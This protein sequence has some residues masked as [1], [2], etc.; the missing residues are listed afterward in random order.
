MWPKQK[1]SERMMALDITEI[2]KICGFSKIVAIQDQMDCTKNIYFCSR[3]DENGDNI[4]DCKTRYLELRFL[5]SSSLLHFTTS[6]KILSNG[7]LHTESA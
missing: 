5:N 1:H 4:L 6:L 7:D 3:L 2:T